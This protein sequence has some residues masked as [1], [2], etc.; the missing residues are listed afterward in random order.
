MSSYIQK[1]FKKSW[2][3]AVPYI[4]FKVVFFMMTSSNGNIFH[5]IGHLCGEFTGPP[6]K[7]QWRGA[8][9]F[10]LICVWINGWVNSGEAGDLRRYRAHYDVTVMLYWQCPL[11]MQLPAS[12]HYSDVIMGA[13]AYQI[14]SP[15][16]V[17]SIVYSGTYQRRHQS[18]ASL[19]FVGEF[20]CDWGIPRTKGQ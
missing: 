11:S 6:Q 20:T 15:T 12:N 9:M 19:A 5:V 16:I 13:M 3:G 14:T 7:G 17:Y 10:S 8:L 4:G 1:I 18:T 2:R